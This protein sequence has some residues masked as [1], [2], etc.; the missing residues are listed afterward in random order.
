MQ[1]SRKPETRPAVDRTASSSD[2]LRQLMSDVIS[3]R[4]EVAQA[5]LAIHRMDGSATQPI[6]RGQPN[7]LMLKRSMLTKL[8]N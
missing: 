7:C 6:N 8:L 5:E 1:F 3:L 2:R 4:E